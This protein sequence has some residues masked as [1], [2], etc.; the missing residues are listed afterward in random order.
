MTPD[1]TQSGG[2]DS[3]PGLQLPN[4]VP[5]WDLSSDRGGECSFPTTVLEGL[6]RRALLEAPD[7]RGWSMAGTCSCKGDGK[8]PSPN[9]GKFT[10]GCVG[11]TALHEETGFSLGY[12]ASDKKWQQD[13]G[14][15]H[16]GKIRYEKQN[17]FL[18]GSYLGI[19]VI[20]FF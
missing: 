11:S 5:P 3:N 9:P 15:E 10:A 2:Q 12:I 20:V 1:F 8:H 18:R 16:F 19:E 17:S 7:A 4:G 6:A 14:L 13:L